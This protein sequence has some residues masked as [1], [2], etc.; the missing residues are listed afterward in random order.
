MRRDRD[1]AFGSESRALERL[2]RNVF[3][4]ERL[5]DFGLGGTDSCGDL[6]EFFD[7]EAVH[8]GG[9]Q[10]DDLLDFV[11]FHSGKREAEMFS[12]ERVRSF[13]MR[14]VRA[15]HNPVAADDFANRALRRRQEARADMA[16][17]CEI[18]GGLE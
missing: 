2:A 17:A 5:R 7:V 8:L 13:D 10:P 9:V 18:L 14:I 4:R 1:L 15:P 3:Q 16:L 11:G 12:G 6:R